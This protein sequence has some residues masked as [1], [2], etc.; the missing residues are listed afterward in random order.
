MG[1][2]PEKMEKIAAVYPWTFHFSLSPPE[3]VYKLRA[4]LLL[5]F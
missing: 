5:F 4:S 1:L 3:K 2:S